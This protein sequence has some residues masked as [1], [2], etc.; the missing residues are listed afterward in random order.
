MKVTGLPAGQ[1]IISSSYE[2]M[3]EYYSENNIDFAGVITRFT[4]D[5]QEQKKIDVV[6]DSKS[7]IIIK[8]QGQD[9]MTFNEGRMTIF[10]KIL[11]NGTEIYYAVW[12]KRFD[13]P[14]I[15]NPII[16][17][18][19]EYFIRIHLIRLKNLN[20]DEIK[21]SGNEFLF[22]IGENE[23]KEISCLILMEGRDLDLHGILIY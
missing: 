1:Y 15:I 21:C 19:G 20:G 7:K 18:P 14:V 13:P 4:L 22:Y 8:L 2:K 9:D 17:E 5:K 12:L 23:T 10:K 3:P 11:I 16:I 6:Y